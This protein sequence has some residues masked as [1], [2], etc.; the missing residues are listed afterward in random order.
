MSN[1]NSVIINHRTGQQCRHCRRDATHTTNV[2][3]LCEFHYNEACAEQQYK[4][5]FNRK[6]GEPICSVD[7]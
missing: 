4:F 7:K 2:G 5:N 3:E 6:Y 1:L